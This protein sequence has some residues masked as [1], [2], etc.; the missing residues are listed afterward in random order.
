MLRFDFPTEIERHPEKI[1]RPAMERINRD[2]KLTF[3]RRIPEVLRTWDV[4]FLRDLSRWLVLGKDPSLVLKYEEFGEARCLEGIPLSEAVRVL[5]ILKN[6][7]M[8]FI[9]SEV[10]DWSAFEVHLEEEF[11]FV[12]GQYFDWVIYHLVHGYE[13]AARLSSANAA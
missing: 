3:V 12:A 9:R 8:E 7:V 11:E 1:V 2:P 10:I 6:Q 13:R 4:D 5:Q